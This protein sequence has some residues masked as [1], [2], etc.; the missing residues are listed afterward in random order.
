MYTR[1]FRT[2][3]HCRKC[4]NLLSAHRTCLAVHLRC[5]SCGTQYRLEDYGTTLDDLLEEYLGNIPC[6]R[7]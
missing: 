5:T 2:N 3:L 4:K 1:N 7:L 6:N